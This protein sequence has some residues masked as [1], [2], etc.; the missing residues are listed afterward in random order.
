MSNE[1]Y[2]RVNILRDRV[3]KVFRTC[4][5]LEQLVVAERYSK[6][7]IKHMVANP[8]HFGYGNLRAYGNEFEMILKF[9]YRTIN[10]IR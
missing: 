7:A 9:K 5:T 4:D 10:T 1:M 6:L 2:D 8:K 3:Y